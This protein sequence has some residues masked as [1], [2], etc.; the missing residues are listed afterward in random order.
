MRVIPSFI[1]KK[2]RWKVFS[3]IESLTVVGEEVEGRQ[4]GSREKPD[5]PTET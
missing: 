5:L 3:L 1:H 2:G 4:Q